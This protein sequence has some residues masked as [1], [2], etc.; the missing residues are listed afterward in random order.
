M[1]KGGDFNAVGKGEFSITGDANTVDS[2]HAAQIF[3]FWLDSGDG[4]R[5]QGSLSEGSAGPGVTKSLWRGFPDAVSTS[6][7]WTFAMPAAWDSAALAVSVY[8]YM[9]TSVAAKAVRMQLGVRN[10]ALGED[11][12]AG[13]ETQTNATVATNNTAILLTI[14]T[15]ASTEGVAAGRL[16]SLSI[17]RLGA[18]AADTHTGELRLLGMRVVAA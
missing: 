11:V 1:N 9:S 13:V 14:H 5:T 12:G 10:R 3:E 17:T 6:Y 7:A 8:F 15:F 18:D 4:Y 16:F 2:I